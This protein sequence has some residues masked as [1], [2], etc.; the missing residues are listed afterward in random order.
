[1]S[2]V[3]TLDNLRS[4]MDKKYAPVEID[5]GKGEPVVLHN[6]MR[7]DSKR[8]QA[9][10]EAIA[11]IQNQDEDTDADEALEGVKTVI[12]LVADDNKGKALNDA[13]GDDVGL[14]MHI[15]ELW[16]EATQPGEASNSPA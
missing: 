2:N 8:R 10:Q 16:S 12:G 6:L 13:I 1:M 15:L 4:E 11:S 9:V 14:A 3:Y 5:L 7:L